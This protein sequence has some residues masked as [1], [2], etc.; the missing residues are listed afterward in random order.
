MPSVDSALCRV[1][2]ILLVAGG[3]VCASVGALL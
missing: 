1:F 2:L 3:A